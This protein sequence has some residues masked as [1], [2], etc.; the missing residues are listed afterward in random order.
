MLNKD[1]HHSDP[2]LRWMSYEATAAG[3]RLDPF[4]RGWD[5]KPHI[6]IHESLTFPWCILEYLR[7][8][9]LT[10]VAQQA[11]RRWYVVSYWPAHWD[12][13]L[14]SFPGFIQAQAAT[15]SPAKSYTAPLLMPKRWTDNRTAQKH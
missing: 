15:F 11:K 8:T 3:L 5:L 7:L 12:T 13:H 6:N 14:M 1:K 10:Y 9:H 4:G 2:P